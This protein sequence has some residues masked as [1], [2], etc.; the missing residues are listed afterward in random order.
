MV[1]PLEIVQQKLADL[2]RYTEKLKEF[3][4]SREE[5]HS[6]LTKQWSVSH[7]LQLAI[8][9]V[10]DV[11]NHLLSDLGV[12]AVDYADV[13]DQ[14]GNQGILPR[15]FAVKIRGMAGFRNVLVHGYSN[16][17]INK[18]Y[19]LLTNNLDDFAA[20]AGHVWRYLA[21]AGRQPP[22]DRTPPDR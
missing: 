4:Y 22:A 5:I 17:D 8:Q 21:I 11:G 2:E 9:I 3:K 16:L 15:E 1:A 19:S 6:D 18:I 13:I 20:F 14:L 12:R 7:G 10:L